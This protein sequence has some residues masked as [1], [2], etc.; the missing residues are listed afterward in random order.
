MFDFARNDEI[1]PD[2]LMISFR[3]MTLIDR[4]L[5]LIPANRRRYEASL[6]ASISLLMD[7]PDM[8]CEIGGIIIPHGRGRD[9]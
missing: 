8:P 6:R 9:A 4:L 3:Q 1:V 2:R 5:L 7:N